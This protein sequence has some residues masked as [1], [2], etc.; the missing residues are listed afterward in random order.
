MAN[1]FHITRGSGA[2]L[3]NEGWVINQ[4][5]H[6]DGLSGDGTTAGLISAAYSVLLNNGYYIGKF[7]DLTD[8]GW[9]IVLDEMD[10]STLTPDSQQ[11]GLVWRSRKYSTVRANFA[12]SAVMEQ[13]NMD[14][15]GNVLSVSYTYPEGYPEDELV[16]K[17]ETT[18]VMV[19][20]FVPEMTVE[21]SRT[22]WGPTYGFLP[23]YDIVALISNRKLQYEGKINSNTWYPIPEYDYVN[24]YYKERFGINDDLKSAGSWLCTGINAVTNDTGV[25]YD[26]TYS[27]AFRKKKEVDGR[28]G[29]YQG[30]SGVYVFI[31]PANSRP[32]ADTDTDSLKVSQIYET[33][34]FSGIWY[35]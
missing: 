6:F 1:K 3:T 16:G 10:F 32:I 31:D 5:A 15:A 8:Y 19:N 2:R 28:A 9:P 29:Y 14:Y 26:V 30:W 24:R 12:T 34:D 25:T 7:L 21:V 20:K 35:V 4:V 33:A 17:T 27:F 23:G 13:T 18:G 11:V 22:E